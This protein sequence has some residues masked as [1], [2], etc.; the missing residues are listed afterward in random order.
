MKQ[1]LKGILIVAAG[2]L[3]ESVRSRILLVSLFFAVVLVGL[4]VAAASISLGEE[5]RLIVDVGLAAASA[6]GSG[7]AL[8]LAIASFAGELRQRTAYTVL[9][10]PIP[11]WAFVLGKHLGIVIT[12]ELLVLLM[13]GSTTLTLWG[14]GAPVPSAM[15]A[16]LWL[17]LVEMQLVVALATLFSA[18]TTPVLAAAFTVGMVL[19]GNLAGDIARFARRLE[20]DSLVTSTL[21]RT[22]YY[23]L[24]DL[25]K[26]S[27]RTQAANDLPVDLTYLMY[28]TAYGLC[29][30]AAALAIACWIF[31][32]RRML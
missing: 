18:M 25:G 12:I 28:G 6:L 16:C 30:A 14:Y 3:L 13:V 2:T 20:E 21:L 9:A 15:W 24:P 4:S 22:L 10:R 7:I 19:G 29:Y 31:A 27:M 26:L 5:G 11:R 32:R 1:A 8:S 17:T 23:L